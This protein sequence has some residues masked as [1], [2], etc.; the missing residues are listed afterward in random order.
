MKEEL[1]LAF[2]EV[3]DDKQLP[4]EVIIDALEAAMVSAYR[5]TVN[6]STAQ[7]IYPQGL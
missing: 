1:V 3:L 2:N 4:K 7:E 5:K 6:A